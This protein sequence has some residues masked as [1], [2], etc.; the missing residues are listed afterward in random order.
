M[1]T[2][3]QAI[4]IYR[5][6]ILS[7]KSTNVDDSEDFKGHNSNI[8][9]TAES[10][11]LAKVYGITPR[12]IRDVW[13]RRSWQYATCHLWPQ[14]EGKSID[15]STLQAKVS[16]KITY[17]QCDINFLLLAAGNKR[18]KPATWTTQGSK[19]PAAST[20]VYDNQHL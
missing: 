17:V 8:S 9:L 13:G 4:D 3:Q 7:E 10:V 6:K 2:E 19:G 11:A 18:I 14:E 16:I 15:P 5:F 20:E 12:A 1:L